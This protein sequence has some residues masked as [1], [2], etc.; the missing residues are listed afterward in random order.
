MTV[1]TTV[2]QTCSA[3]LSP[4]NP[5]NSV[6]AEARVVCYPQVDRHRS[7]FCLDGSR[8]HD[9]D[10]LLD[11]GFHVLSYEL[12]DSDGHILESSEIALSK[13]SPF[14]LSPYLR[15]QRMS[16]ASQRQLQ[17]ET[18]SIDWPLSMPQAPFATPGERILSDTELCLRLNDDTGQCVL[19]IEDEEGRR[20][21]YALGDSFRFSLKYPH[22]RLRLIH[23][24]TGAAL[25]WSVYSPSLENKDGQP[26]A[27][28]DT[29]YSESFHSPAEIERLSPLDVSWAAGGFSASELS[30]PESDFSY[31]E[32]TSQDGSLEDDL[33]E[34]G[35]N[36]S[37][38][39]AVYEHPDTPQPNPQTNGTD[40]SDPSVLNVE[41]AFTYQDAPLSDSSWN[42]SASF[43]FM[44]DRP[45]AELTASV[46]TDSNSASSSVS[47][48]DDPLLYS[49]FAPTGRQNPGAV[50][51]ADPEKSLRPSSRKYGD[52]LLQTALKGNEKAYKPG[53]LIFTSSA[54]DLKVD[55]QNGTLEAFTVQSLDTQKTYESLEQAF[56]A[57]SNSAFQIQAVFLDARQQKV[58]QSWTVIDSGKMFQEQIQLPGLRLKRFCSLDENGRMIRRD[59]L[60][61][62]EVML[63]RGF[64]QTDGTDIMPCEALRLYVDDP[65][66]SY[67]LQIDGKEQ[68]AKLKEDELGQPYLELYSARKNQR[69]EVFKDGQKLD[70]LTLPVKPASAMGGLILAC[71]LLG[72][73]AA[74]GKRRRLRNASLR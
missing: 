26:D 37:S 59:A 50:L 22:S 73:F 35:G 40:L 30:R 1:V 11:E 51:S 3:S 63:C 66:A 7:I 64:V 27:E 5:A 33:P 16:S 69:V 25:E 9:L 6:F 23:V 18:E 19:E 47:L 29:G 71:G 44:Q 55:V 46:F 36:D 32:N 14:L 21:V 58:D 65:S 43:S 31:S 10:L 4:E 34:E 70:T 42:S 56:D 67:A 45:S 61:R 38:D 57:E 20:E 12:Q 15:L 28:P 41:N 60:H 53:E 52:S 17:E 48:L 68:P 8:L 62:K 74:D 49:P 2:M 24:P 54:Q 72:G 13:D 39:F